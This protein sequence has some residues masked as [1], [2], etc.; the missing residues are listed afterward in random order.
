MSSGTVA[1]SP[2]SWD[3]IVTQHSTRVFRLAYRLT[4]N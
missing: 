4:G 2:P 3:E 1:W